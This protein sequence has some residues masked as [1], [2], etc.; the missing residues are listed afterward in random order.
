MSVVLDI[1]DNFWLISAVSAWFIAQFLKVLTG[2]FR[3][4]SFS[5]LTLMFST[6]G[7]PSSHTASVVALTTAAGLTFGLSSF[8]FAATF[9]FSMVVMIDAMGVRRETG[10]QA[11]I[12]NR[13]M[14]EFLIS[15]DPE[16]WNRTLKELIG[17]TPLQV[18]AGAAV[19]VIVP[20]VYWLTPWF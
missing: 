3:D 15:K 10:E 12:I 6:G 7:M 17:H 5:L 9:M 4:R 8:S 2:M 11:K 16:L 14:K 18:A 13:M 19:G 20:V 1:L